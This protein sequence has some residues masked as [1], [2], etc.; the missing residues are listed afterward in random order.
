[1]IKI[2]T[3]LINPVSPD[4]VEFLSD[5]VLGYEDGRITLLRPYKP[6]LDADAEQALDS[7]MLPGFI[8][9]HV[10]LSQYRARGR[11]EPALLPWLQKHIFP[12]EA[13]SAD[14]DYARNLAEDF[15]QGLFAA[16]TTSAVIYT[17]PFRQA[18]DTAFEAASLAGARALIGMTLMD[19]NI[20]ETL[21]QTTSY[22]YENSV[23]LYETWHG[24]PLLDYIFTPRFAPTC[25]PE[26][27]KL[28][29]TYAEGHE[30]FIQSHLS[31]NRDE[32]AWVKEL[33]GKGSYTQ[34]Y[35]DLGLLGHRTIM[36]HAIHLSDGELDL[37][38][39]S[40][41]AIAHCPDSNFFLKSGE[42]PYQSIWERGIRMGL[43]SDVGAGTT[44]SMPHHAQMASYR[45]STASLTPQRLLWHLTM[46]AAAV[47]GWQ[48][49][50]GSLAPGKAAD[51]C[52]IRI[53]SDQLLDSD[54]LSGL[55]YYGRE[56]KVI[57]TIVGG[58]AVY[59]P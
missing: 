57:R 15:F 3:K 43:G 14:P 17:A 42:F 12:A 51:L 38:A 58:K 45:Q 16:G 32:I 6:E 20:P 56:F 29:A 1:M 10:H 11:Y 21:V 39:E 18:C 52:L 41:T 22:A 9:L 47:L 30:A 8:D 55:C 4:R 59:S 27:M 2:R 49:C 53:P 25:S 36:G 5:H 37:L 23:D 7:F 35:S 31:E 34:V 46:G 54:L 24:K 28:I 13:L 19:R 48:D 44:L 50:I 40:N 26:L 33:F